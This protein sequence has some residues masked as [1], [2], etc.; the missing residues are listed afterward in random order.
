[1]GHN[2]DEVLHFMIFDRIVTYFLY[3]AVS[4]LDKEHKL[5]EKYA[6]ALTIRRE[7]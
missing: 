4:N 6:P 3:S 2:Q 7:P 1:M 5:N